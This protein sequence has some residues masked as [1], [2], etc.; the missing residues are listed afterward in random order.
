VK[1]LSYSRALVPYLSDD[2]VHQRF[3]ALAMTPLRFAGRANARV[4]ANFGNIRERPSVIASR[5]R[6]RRNPVCARRIASSRSQ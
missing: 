5:R 3:T 1:N 2:L 4:S 6:R